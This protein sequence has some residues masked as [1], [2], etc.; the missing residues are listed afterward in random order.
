M[1]CMIIFGYFGTLDSS[2][3]N[4]ILPNLVLLNSL[5]ELLSEQNVKRKKLVVTATGGVSPNVSIHSALAADEIIYTRLIIS[6]FK[7]AKT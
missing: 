6:I 2:C 7:D 5:V 4:S 1:S 3:I